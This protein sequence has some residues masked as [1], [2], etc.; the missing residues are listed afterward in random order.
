M[1]EDLKKKMEDNI[2][3]EEKIARRT[4]GA[5]GCYFLAIFLQVF[6]IKSHEYISQ[7]TA[8]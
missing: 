8:E 2:E 5:K 4:T 3:E 1:E 6:N 7:L